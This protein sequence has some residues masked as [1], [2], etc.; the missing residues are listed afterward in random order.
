MYDAWGRPISK[1]GTLA[2][3]LGTVQPFRYRGYVFDEETYQYYLGGRY[4]CSS[5]CRFS[6]CD[7]VLGMKGHIGEVNTFAYCLNHP[8][9]LLDTNGQSP[10]LAG[11]DGFA[12]ADAAAV[13]ALAVMYSICQYT[14]MEL[15]TLIYSYTSDEGALLYGYTDIVFGTP[16]ACKPFEDAPYTP[17]SMVAYAHS[18]P[19]GYE[20]SGN[21]KGTAIGN[22]C[23]AYV[24]YP[25]GTL[26]K[27]TNT[28]LKQAPGSPP[29][30]RRPL[31]VERVEHREFILSDE[32]LE[33]LRPRWD[34]HWWKEDLSLIH[35]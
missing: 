30:I 34:T 18:Y 23:H 2:N 13:E 4:Y 17:Q 1:T 29:V 12:S 14:R 11:K 28:F 31:P 27:F 22:N 16:H 20:F 33:L 10:T 26:D 9:T 32:T 24:V 19:N 6:N 35:I 15:S 5:K 7:S 8:V 3:T 21:D 25:D